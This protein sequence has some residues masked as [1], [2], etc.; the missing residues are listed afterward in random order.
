MAV[1]RRAR[2]GRSA[3]RT[4]VLSSVLLSTL[5]LAACGPGPFSVQERALPGSSPLGATDTFYSG[6]DP[7]QWY[8]RTVRAPEAWGL[9]ASLQQDPV[10][11]GDL[12][13]T[14]VAVIDTWIDT[15]HPDLAGVLTA[16][17][18]KGVAATFGQGVAT[19]GT[20]VAGLA[21]GRGDDQSGIAGIAYNR[22]TTVAVALLPVWGLWASD[23]TGENASTPSSELIRALVGVAAAQESANGPLVVNLSLGASTFSDAIADLAIAELVAGGALLVAASGNSNT[24]RVDWPARL[25]DVMAI[26]SVDYAADRTAS[27]RSGF[28]NYGP[29]LDIVAPGAFGPDGSFASGFRGI[30][31]AV[32]GPA[33]ALKAG[34]SMATPL[35]AGAAATVW[36]A[37]PRLS[38][39]D[40]RSILRETALD[41]GTP[42]RDD[43]TGY[44]LLDMEAALRAAVSSPWGRYTGQSLAPGPQN[45]LMETLEQSI[46]TLSPPDSNPD[47][48]LVLGMPGSNLSAAVSSAA[49]EAGIDGDGFAVRSLGTLA[50]GH[51]LQVVLPADASRATRLVD[52]LRTHPAVRGLS[53]DRPL[54]LGR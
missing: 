51:V 12:S 49:A 30:I 48:L 40:L 16:P 1:F 17:L 36:S 54:R 44:G 50:G 5:L 29:R 6:T 24:A 53:W 42:G 35:V 31:S 27:T 20:H 28:S 18:L 34:T 23:A 38:A 39:G 22:G 9:Y 4:A 46:E 33:W 45:A 13:T 19:H 37:N 10:I 15:S 11:A 7:D 43:E 21:A 25:P 3:P 2:R 26:G 32:P 52:T 47:A 14:T 8:L 41:L